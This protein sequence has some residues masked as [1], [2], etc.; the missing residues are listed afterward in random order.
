[1]L[2]FLEAI[3]NKISSGTA[4]DDTLS[5]HELQLATAALLVEVATI[6]QHLDDREKQELQTLLIK[7]C[8]LTDD[9]AKALMDNALEASSNAASLYDFTQSINQHCSYPQKLSLMTGLWRVAYADEIL[10]KYEEHIIRRIADL[11]HVSHSD[12]I[13]T[14]IQVRDRT[15]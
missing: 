11:I 2:T 7:T 8:E 12:F 9:E 13:Q 14:K 1:M 10:D 15:E 4:V 3:I 6:D 5:E